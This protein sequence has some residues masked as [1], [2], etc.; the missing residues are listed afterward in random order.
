MTAPVALVTG[1]ARGIGRAIVEE[2]LAEGW[3]VAF[4]WRSH[5]AGATEVEAAAAGAAV[6]LRLDLAD[7]RA[8]SALVPRVEASLG[9]IDGLVNNAG[10]QESRLLGLTSDE[11]WDRILDVNLG[12]TFRCCRA[13]LPRMVHRRQGAIV[14][15]ASLAALHGVAGLAA[16]AAAKAGVLALTR[17]LAREV[18]K[19]GV[20]VNAVVYGF[21]ATEMTA[22]L[23]PEVAATL[24]AGE[25]LP[26]GVDARGAASAVAFLLSER[27][28]AI[29]GQSL[30]VDA[31]ASA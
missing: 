30:V 9:P 17:C 16:Y 14:N 25:A 29:T 23:A 11:A 5:E 4:T 12:G 8:C 2:L 15:V 7:R 20:R 27:S 18:G 3:R 6:A 10:H 19:R 31:G 1:G 21:V 24:R 28:R 13:V 26:G 22:G